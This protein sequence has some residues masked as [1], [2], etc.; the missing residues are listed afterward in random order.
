MARR[1]LFFPVFRSG[2]GAVVAH[3]FHTRYRNDYGQGGHGSR[4][5]ANEALSLTSHGAHARPRRQVSGPWG[6]LVKRLVMELSSP[7]RGPSARPS[8]V[9]MS[10][11]SMGDPSRARP[12]G[13]CAAEGD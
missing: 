7:T 9:H 3:Q 2:I 6:P 13:C 12:N 11:W 8:L 1:P 10:R 5:I 4:A